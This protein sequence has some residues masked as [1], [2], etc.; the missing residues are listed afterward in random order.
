M[1]VWNRSRSTRSAHSISETSSATSPATISQS[2]SDSDRRR[3]TTSR[4]LGLLTCTSL[5]PSNLPPD[6]TSLE[7]TRPTL[8]MSEHDVERPMTPPVRDDHL[9]AVESALEV[10]MIVR[11]IT[12]TFVACIA[13]LI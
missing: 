4:F 12:L 2:L 9:A 8:Y 13:A 7:I 3:S 6:A 11:Q 1:T 5:I 10:C